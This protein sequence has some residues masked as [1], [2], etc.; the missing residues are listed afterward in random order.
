MLLQIIFSTFSTCPVGF[1]LCSTILANQCDNLIEY[2]VRWFVALS[3]TTT[4]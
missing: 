2:D 1:I 4:K 3:I